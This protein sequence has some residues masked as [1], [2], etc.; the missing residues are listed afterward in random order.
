MS[1]LRLHPFHIS[2]WVLTFSILFGFVWQ[3]SSR[4]RDWRDEFTLWSKTVAREPNSYKAHS[5]LGILL[6]KRGQ[7]EEGISELQTS[8]S[9]NP[10]Y[11]DAH[12]N[13][14]TL[15]EQKGMYDDAAKEYRC[16]LRLNPTLSEA[17]YN[18]G[19][20]YLNKIILFNICRIS[21]QRVKNI[22]NCK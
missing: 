22:K 7:E 17:H 16:A 15:Y 19:N 9:M 12:N 1:A 10:S 2:V 8:L 13:M 20:T 6:I 18:L 3:T 11:P 4:S 14:G 21:S 5:S